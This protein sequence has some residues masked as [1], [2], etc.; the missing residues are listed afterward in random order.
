MLV[1][2]P[3]RFWSSTSNSTKFAAAFLLFAQF[4]F[5][6][7]SFLFGS[8]DKQVKC[9]CDK[10]H[11]PDALVCS[12]KWC[13]IGMRTAED[14]RG[15]LDQ[16]CGKE[17]DERPAGDCGQ[18][19]NNWSEVCACKE[20]FCNTFAHLRTNIDRRNALNRERTEKS[21]SVL[22]IYGR[23]QPAEHY[24][25]E[26][27]NNSFMTAIS[28]PSGSLVLLLVIVPISV[29]GFAMC[30]IFLNYHCNMM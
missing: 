14:D 11:C 24:G 23:S 1:L 7:N 26:D 12:G 9:F 21:G 30:L 28:R 13:L 3:N 22:N 16:E 6:V 18:Q 25:A 10:M 5:R 2:F 8:E 17:G 19:W 20:D 27:E 29:G 15:R 4:S